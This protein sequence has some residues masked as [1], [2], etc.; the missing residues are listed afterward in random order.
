[1]SGRH[2]RPLAERSL[3][4]RVMGA[5]AAGLA[6][7]FAVAPAALADA[8]APST[9]AAP[10]AASNDAPAASVV[11]DFG[12]Q[13][14]RVGVQVKDGSWVPP[15]TS[16]VNTHIK[17]IETGP[18]VDGVKKTFCQTKANT[19]T[20]QDDPSATFCK[21]PLDDVRGPVTNS[22]AIPAVVVSPGPAHLPGR[23]YYIVQ[24]GDTVR[25]FQ[26]TVKPNLVR[27]KEIGKVGPCQS[28][29][30]D[31]PICSGSTDVIFQD[32]GLPPLA[33]DDTATTAMGQSVDIDVLAND[34][35]QGAPENVDSATD[36]AHGTVHI[37]SGSP[38][39]V[40]YTPDA[41]FSGVDTFHYS[42]STPNGTSTAL[43]TVTIPAAPATSTP[44]PN[45]ATPPPAAP[46]VLANTGVPTN[47]LEDLATALLLL[48]G[49]A[50]VIGRRRY[51][52][53][54]V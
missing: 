4:K 46:D 9:T 27:D 23:R 49:A 51:R 45:P 17:I 35:G 31:E 25:V 6:A 30:V 22:A 8:P 11:P 36:P 10:D 29:L 38:D 7:V 13:K 18:G 43:V 19:A 44:P 3:N 34:Q 28:D 50:T 14:I 42:M 37:N 32:P 12:Y 21:F 15:G 52:G 1:M 41:G 53:R 33:V 47:T 48:G 16:T 26:T 20:K 5:G 24:P 39:T 54:H 2:R 40:T